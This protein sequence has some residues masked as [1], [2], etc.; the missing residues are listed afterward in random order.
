MRLD[1]KAKGKR[2]EYYKRWYEENKEKKNRY[3]KQWRAENPKK[4][5]EY[6]DRYW[7]K[8]AM[9]GEMEE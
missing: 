7:T 4:V 9:E 1:D 6:N 3:N 5:A 2:S 8:K